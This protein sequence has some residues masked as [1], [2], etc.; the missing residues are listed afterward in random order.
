VELRAYVEAIRRR[1]WILLLGPVL[2]G[3]AAYLVSTAMTP[4]YRASALI[5]VNQ[6]ETAGVVQYNDVLTSERLT[7]TYAQL[8]ERRPVLTAVR[9]QLDLPIGEDQLAAMIDVSTVASTQLLRIAVESADPTLAALA[10]NATSQVFIADNASHLSRPGTVSVV[11]EAAVP[12]APVKP[13]I[14]LNTALAVV[15][16]LVVAGLAVFAVE[17]LDDTVK[18]ADDVEALASITSLGVVNRFGRDEGRQ[19]VHWRP[20]SHSGE[21]YRQLRTTIHFARLAGEIKAITVT[22][23]NPREGK[24]TTVANLAVVLAH[25]GE[26]VIAIDTDL[27]RPSLHSLFGVANSFGLTGLLLSEVDDVRQALVK[28][29]VKNLSV[30]PSGPQP[31]NPSELLTSGLMDP[32]LAALRE[33]ADILLFDSPPILA[34]TD[35]SILAGRTDASIL[36]IETGRTRTEA[37]RRAAQAL[38]QASPRLLGT[39]LNK[40]QGR[41][42]SYYGGYYRSDDPQRNESAA[43]ARA[44]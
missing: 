9:D 19:V 8:V 40:A 11:E 12:T 34:V 28:T 5:L 15:L 41:R 38:R 44:K 13:R 37:V 14:A 4:I 24:S 7:N 25:A 42:A 21:A 29:S 18:S 35:A 22:S 31:P 10:A 20:D 23:A 17:Y 39:V 1:W 2:A 3:L 30:L 26:R 27:R 6:T 36:V 43:A 33:H 32:I 16:G